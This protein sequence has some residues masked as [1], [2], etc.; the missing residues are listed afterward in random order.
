MAQD[1]K[2][3]TIILRV[4]SDLKKELQKMA[5]L[6]SRTL[7][8]FIRVQLRKLVDLSKKKK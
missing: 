1:T 4:E 3:D 2:T 6:D 5:E 7:A 8:D